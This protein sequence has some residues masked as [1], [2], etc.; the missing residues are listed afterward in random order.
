M[1]M[2]AMTFDKFLEANGERMK[3]L[4]I[5]MREKKIHDAIRCSLENFEEFNYTDKLADNAVRHVTIFPL[6]AISRLGMM[7]ND[8]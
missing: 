7:M 1:F 8:E 2:Y 4:W 6:Y 3:S 5:F